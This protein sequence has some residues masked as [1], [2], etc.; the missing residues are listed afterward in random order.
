MNQQCRW[1]IMTIWVAIHTDVVK[2]DTHSRQAR[3]ERANHVLKTCVVAHRPRTAYVFNAILVIYL[4][5][6]PVV[7]DI[8]FRR[9][10]MTRQ[11][12]N[13]VQINPRKHH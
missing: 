8:V 7:L 11:I 9:P 1:I 4:M 2:R 13:M 6:P 5:K 12:C 3:T 10:D